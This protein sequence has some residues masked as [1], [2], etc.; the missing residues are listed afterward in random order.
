MINWPLSSW[1]FV[2]KSVNSRIQRWIMG[3]IT[4]M[5][6]ISAGIENSLAKPPPL[7]VDLDGTLVRTDTLYEQILV[8]L[9]SAP[10]LV[11]K[12][13]RWVFLGKAGFKSQVGCYAP[14]D[15]TLLP[16]DRRVL[17]FLQQ[18]KDRG[19]T[20][21]LVTAADRTIA[22]VIADHLGLF[23]RVLA[24]DGVLN[25]SRQSRNQTG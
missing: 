22:G 23:D 24:S 9:L 7:C 15:P 6:A 4:T 13:L 8:L 10:W 20:I 14:L 18:E 2:V 12:L 19:R 1:L 11:F 3:E 25:L 16:Y 17:D 21:V 5:P